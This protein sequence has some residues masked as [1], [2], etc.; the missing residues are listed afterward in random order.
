[1]KAHRSG[2][3]VPLIL[4]LELDG[5]TWPKSQPDRCIPCKISTGTHR[6]GGC[7]GSTLCLDDVQKRTISLPAGN[8]KKIPAQFSP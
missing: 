8:R 3:T 7:I 1:M 5:G 6:K 2:D 4:T